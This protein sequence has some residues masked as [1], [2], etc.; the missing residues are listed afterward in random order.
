MKTPERLVNSP[1]VM[2]SQWGR[3]RIASLENTQQLLSLGTCTCDQRT[4]KCVAQCSNYISSP[5]PTSTAALSLSV[6]L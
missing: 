2:T 3:Q 6:Q 5:S 4:N 1:T